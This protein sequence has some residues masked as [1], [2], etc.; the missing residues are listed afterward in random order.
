MACTL[1]VVL[2]VFNVSA[3]DIP[4]Y[5]EAYPAQLDPFT[6]NWRGEWT[7]GDEKDPW[8]AAQIVPLGKSKYRITLMNLLDARCP[9][10]HT[11]EATADGD[12]LTFRNDTLFG[13]I[14][15]GEFTGG[16]VKEE[17]RFRLS[18]IELESPTLG[19]PPPNGA[20]VLFDGS[21]V[22]AFWKPRGWVIT[23]D[24]T[25]LVT[26]K[27]PDV[28]TKEKFSSVQL[29]LEFRLPYRPEKRGQDRGNSGVFLQNHYEV[30]ILDSFGLDGL[31]DECGAIYK[32]AA[33]RVN[34]CRPPL[35]WQTYDITYH[36]PRFDARDNLVAL[37]RMSVLQNGVPVH[38]DQQ[39]LWPTSGGGNKRRKAHPDSPERIRFQ[40]HGDFME[41]RN[42]WL[43]ELRDDR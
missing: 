25:L 10:L 24:H 38:T 11:T 26:P 9:K 40:E 30:Q 31:Y 18:R 20:V 23:P 43:V 15:G 1:L 6:G 5:A 28:S 12:R 14:A 36:A 22:D 34:A 7:K 42:I 16:K 39:L 2:N 35:Q 27:S 13:A 4:G 32:I 3:E 33:P 37:G 8:L 41:Y 19:E 17:D 29:H 21:S